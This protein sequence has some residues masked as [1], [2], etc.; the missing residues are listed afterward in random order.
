MAEH[1]ARKRKNVKRKTK[2]INIV[3]FLGHQ[4]FTFWFISFQP[5]PLPTTHAKYIH[6]YML[7]VLGFYWGM[8]FFN[9][10]EIIYSFVPALFM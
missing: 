6:V 1:L 7:S 3:T 5:L 2:F 10:F 4:Q 9:F 8:G